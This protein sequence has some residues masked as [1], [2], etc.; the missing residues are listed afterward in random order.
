MGSLVVFLFPAIDCVSGVNG[1]LIECS[2]LCF[3]LRI[4]K[5]PGIYE[6][7]GHIRDDGD[8]TDTSVDC[9]QKPCHTRAGAVL[10][11]LR[12]RLIGTLHLPPLAGL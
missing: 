8:Y 7:V 12:A 1:D 2:S 10:P 9:P 4:S 6:E 5:Q 3:H 11:S